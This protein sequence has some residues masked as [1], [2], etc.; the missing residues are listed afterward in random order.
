MPCLQP[1]TSAAPAYTRDRVF[2]DGGGREP[3][4]ECANSAAERFTSY[5][6]DRAKQYVPVRT[7]TDTKST[8]PWLNERCF[9]AVLKK[10]AAEGTTEYQACLQERSRTFLEEYRAYVAKTKEKLRSLPRS[11]KLWWRLSRFLA[12]GGAFV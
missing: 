5:L 4:I 2:F 10:R 3:N 11:S 6:L 7:V 9:Q 8:H 12:T 1:N